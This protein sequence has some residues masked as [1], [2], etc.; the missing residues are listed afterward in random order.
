MN[1][2][3]SQPSKLDIPFVIMG[4]FFVAMA[5]VEYLVP[6]GSGAS[7]L[8]IKVLCGVQIAFALS[9]AVFT[10]CSAIFSRWLPVSF[11]VLLLWLCLSGMIRSDNMRDTLY[12]WTMYLYWYSLFV[13]FYSRSLIYPERLQVFLVIAVFSLLIWIPALRKSITLVVGNIYLSTYQLKQNYIGYYIVALFPYALMLK[14]K[15]LKLI[16]IALISFGT[17]YSLKRGAVLALVLMGFSSSFLYVTVVTDRAKRAR[18]IMALI[19]LWTITVMV[20]GLF[21][22]ANSDIVSHRLNQASNREEVYKRAFDAIENAE[23]YELVIGQGDRKAEAIIG[24]YTHNDWLFLLYDYGI[25]GVMLMLN[26]YV[27]LMWLLWKLYKL[28]SPLLLPL[29]SSFVLM[30]GVQLY[31]IGLYLK[32]FGYITGSI[33]LVLGSYY[34]EQKAIELTMKNNNNDDDLTD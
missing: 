18:N 30:V 19:S 29:L 13:F 26:V 32:T 7:R 2:P 5:L 28:R 12:L 4:L 25:I 14:K 24:C 1:E 11:L 3:I 9:I 27:A 20:V 10:R 8:V 17:V 23:F 22:W 34:S 6:E 33:G 21:V 31:S 16:A 15:S